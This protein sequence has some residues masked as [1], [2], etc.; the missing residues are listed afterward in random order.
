MPMEKRM[1]SGLEVNVVGLGT[2]ATFQLSHT[3]TDAETRAR[4]QV[5]DSCLE[6]ET[7]F[8]DSSPMYG[9]SERMVGMAT[10]G[11]MQRFQLATKVWTLG[12]KAGRAQVANSFRLLRTDYIDVLQIH[13]LVDWRVHLPEMERLKEEGKIGLIGLTHYETS[14]YPEM[15]S[16]M[17]TRRVHTIQIPYNLLQ[18][19]CEEQVLPLAEELG[20]GV[21]VMRPLGGGTLV[22]DLRS[23]PDLSPLGPYGIKSCA[24]A[25]LAWVLAD[26]RVS[27]AIPAT[28]KWE[29]VAENALVGTLL[30]MPAEL[31]DYV[32]K[33]V[34]RCL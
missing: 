22:R 13:N 2:A 10:D 17:K 3:P 24:Q 21:I 31:R 32:S 30:P 11:R 23:Q 34:L 25:L 6:N 15:I 9:E 27:V 20:I 14:S 16:I 7:T 28:T 1:L 26:P 29:R 33:E 8:I 4:Q 19:E 5:I 18:R 12:L